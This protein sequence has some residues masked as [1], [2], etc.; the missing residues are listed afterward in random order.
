MPTRIYAVV[1]AAKGG[2]HDPDYDTLRDD[3][4]FKKLLARLK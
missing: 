2:A 1:T 3:P 4:R